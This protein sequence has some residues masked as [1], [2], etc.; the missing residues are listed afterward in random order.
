VGVFQKRWVLSR[1]MRVF[2]MLQAD[3]QPGM[4]IGMRE[5]ATEGRSIVTSVD[6]G[7]L[8]VSGVFV[9]RILC[10]RGSGDG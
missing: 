1:M 10:R 8:R 6:Q 9:T 2:R 7:G 5:F 4:T 3:G